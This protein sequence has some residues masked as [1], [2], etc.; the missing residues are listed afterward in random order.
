MLTGKD[1]LEH[2]SE[3]LEDFTLNAPLYMKEILNRF[4]VVSF[5]NRA[6]NETKKQ[7][8]NELLKIIAD[9][10]NGHLSNEMYNSIEEILLRAEDES[11]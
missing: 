6:T 3:T 5:N 2:E 7:Q 4:P 11:V 1:D 10:N 8:T 9:Q